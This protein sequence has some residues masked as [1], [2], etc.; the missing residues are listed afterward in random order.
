MSPLAPTFVDDFNV[1]T[2]SSQPIHVCQLW[3]SVVWEECEGAVFKG[4]MFKGGKVVEAYEEYS[5]DV[6]EV[7]LGL[8]STKSGLFDDD[9]FSTGVAVSVNINGRNGF[10]L[11]QNIY[12][13]L[14]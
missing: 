10:I 13:L 8:A 11:I 14:Y 6:C 5:D 1:S 4:G 3:C 7:E 12:N 9:C 2:S